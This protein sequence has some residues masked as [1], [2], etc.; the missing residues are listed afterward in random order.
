[1][2]AARRF[3]YSA[4]AFHKHF[5]SPIHGKRHCAALRS[6]AF[7]R[8]RCSSL[9]SAPEQSAEHPGPPLNRTGRMHAHVPVRHYRPHAPLI[10]QGRAG[11]RAGSGTACMRAWRRRAWLVPC[12]VWCMGA[13][14]L[15]TRKW[16][17]PRLP[18]FIMYGSIAAFS[19]TVALPV[20]VRH[21]TAHGKQ[22]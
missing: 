17:A 19:R 15:Y 14:P 16:L 10:W 18:R 12:G 13:L 2:N 4:A 20:A 3:S 22:K 11:K 9:R 7:A 6:V 21:R 5:S 1:M 8:S